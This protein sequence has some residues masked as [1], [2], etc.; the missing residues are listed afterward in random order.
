MRE[1]W[2]DSDRDRVLDHV[3]VYQTNPGLRDRLVRSR[4]VIRFQNFLWEFRQS[5]SQ[6]AHPL[7]E[8]IL[9]TFDLS[10][11]AATSRY[12]VLTT[13][14]AFV[15]FW[16]SFI[17]AILAGSITILIFLT[18]TARKFGRKMSKFV[19]SIRTR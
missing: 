3:P 8:K 17:S 6:A 13:L 4:L 2:Q 1:Q 10:T 9:N 14:I 12:S 18:T 15:I 7:R 11:L 16:M 5:F 19:T